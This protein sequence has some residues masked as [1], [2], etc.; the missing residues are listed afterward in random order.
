ML[1]EDTEKV[2]MGTR[3]GMITPSAVHQ[4]ECAVGTMLSTL[5]SC[6]AHS[7]AAAEHSGTGSSGVVGGAVGGIA[8]L[9]DKVGQ[10]GE[11]APLSPT[12]Q[13]LTGIDCL[14][15]IYGLDGFYLRDMYLLSFPICRH[16]S[17]F[18]LF[19]LLLQRS[20]C[21]LCATR[22]SPFSA[23]SKANSR[24]P[25]S[26]PCTQSAYYLLITYYWIIRGYVLEIT[27]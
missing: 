5:L 14:Q 9:G 12:E 21:T 15:A 27:G 10:V 25:M 11:D 20:F 4:L 23:C 13:V 16:C 3:T 1:L 26:L 7:D 19:S 8:P 6:G 24:N 17:L 18:V 2:L 22:S